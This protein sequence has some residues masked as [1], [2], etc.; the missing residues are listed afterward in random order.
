MAY[1]KIEEKDAMLLV[2]ALGLLVSQAG[3]YGPS[4]NVTQ[5]TA[6]SVFAELEQTIKSCGPIEI[7][8]RGQQILINGSSDGIS[9]VTGRNLSDRMALHKITG[10]LFLSPPDSREFLKCITLFGTQPLALAAEGGFESAVK[11]EMLRSVQVVAVAYQR[12]A[13]EKPVAAK[14]DVPPTSPFVAKRPEAP[15]VTGVLD[16]SDAFR[17]VEKEPDP[18][19]DEERARREQSAQLAAL[20]REMAAQ[21]ESGKG[22]SPQALQT[23]VEDA[24]SRV[25]G[26]L[27]DMAAESDRRI[28]T[29]ADQVSEDR[30]TIA[31][32]ESAA[33]R[34]GIV[35]QLTRG[36]LVQRY[37]ELN[38]EIVQPLTVSTGVIDMLAS[39]QAGV[40][41]ETQRDL[42]K[43]AS[44]SVER[45]NQLVAY[46]NRI[47]GVPDTFTP[48]HSIIADSYR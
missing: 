22:G 39:G 45:V 6:F 26:F 34:R 3:V 33:R 29:L 35:L 13:G 44:E 32:I 8:L 31:S 28:S 11:K 46:M 36:E 40:L 12:V 30:Q 48:D 9:E 4:H 7:A 23:N 25:R 14:P 10:L 42:L 5:R 2:R 16:L 41:T 1:T 47:S 15:P 17:E 37:A 27:S 21:L 43:M 18:E 19:Q 24:L 20:L 38:Q